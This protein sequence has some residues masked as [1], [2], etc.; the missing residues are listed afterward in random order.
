MPKIMLCQ[1]TPVLGVIDKNLD[2]HIGYIE[3]AIAE[4]CDVV[5]FPELSLT[6]Y[7]LRDL[8][9]DVAIDEK[10][11]VFKKMLNYSK[12]ITI[13]FGFVYIDS[14][15]LVYNAAA[16]IDNEKVVHIHKKVF[17]PDYTMFEEARYFAHGK[18]FDVFNGVLNKTSILICEDAL[19]ISCLYQ[20]FQK[21]VSAI[22][23]LSNSPAR[24]I[25]KEKFYSQ[26]LWETTNKYIAMGLTAYVI[27]LNRVGV[28]DGIT[29]WGGSTI[30]GPEGK[31]VDQ[32]SILEEDYKIVSL[33][34]DIVKKARVTSPFY[35]DDKYFL[36]N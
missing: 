10:H 32:L 12:Y 27:Y 8:V 15:F 9:Y 30:F 31:K 21:G 36:S 18:S 17:L 26:N 20:L 29:F 34:I 6:G 4:K 11:N 14:D 19:H 13:V 33:D 23:I 5:V 22:F 3:K 2:A 1:Y 35:R 16:Y 28:E 7:C 25:Y 24:G